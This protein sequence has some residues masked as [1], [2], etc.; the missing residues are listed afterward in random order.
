MNEFTILPNK[1]ILE[2]NRLFKLIAK[3]VTEI[4]YVFDQAF[5]VGFVGNIISTLDVGSEQIWRCPY[6]NIFLVNEVYLVNHL[7]D[8]LDY[9]C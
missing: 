9:S 4:V 5:K 7:R 8:I 6:K 2:A 1:L 3:F